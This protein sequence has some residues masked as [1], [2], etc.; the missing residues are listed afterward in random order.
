MKKNLFTKIIF[1]IIALFLLTGC[2]DLKKY[3]NNGLII[4][5]EKGLFYKNHETATV[6][7]EN[8]NFFVI[9]LHEKFEDLYQFDINNETT[10]SEYANA[11]FLNQ[12]KS[13]DLIKDDNLY[14]Y[15]YEHEIY[16][17]TY[18][19]VSTIHKS[20]D[21]FWICNFACPLKNK[22]AYHDKFISWAKSITFYK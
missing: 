4:T 10:I 13:F 20:D 2:N 12:E 17:N 6:Y 22:E 15:T 5:M 3:K 7:Y 14:Y 18:Y 16:D 19:Y 21:G 11:V 1:I 9:A 8:E